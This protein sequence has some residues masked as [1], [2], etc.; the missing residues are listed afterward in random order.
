[1]RKVKR[2]IPMPRFATM[3]EAV[4]Y[5]AEQ[6]LTVHGDDETLKHF[7]RLLKLAVDESAPSYSEFGVPAAF[8]H[9][10][11]GFYK[12]NKD[13]SYSVLGTDLML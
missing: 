2:K 13:K 4:E 9:T 10:G 1:M 11:S 12:N 7:Y 5:L 6:G 3:K 8:G